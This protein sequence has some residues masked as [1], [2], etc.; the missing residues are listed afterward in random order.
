MS[1]KDCKSATIAAQNIFTDSLQVDKGEVVSISAQPGAASTVTLQRKIDGV[2]WRDVE[3]WAVDI[4]LSYHTDEACLLQ[5]GV[6]TGDYGASTTV[7]I[8]K[9]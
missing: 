4:E 5:I 8:G 7:R 1:Y 2:N 3:Q 6:K 9:G